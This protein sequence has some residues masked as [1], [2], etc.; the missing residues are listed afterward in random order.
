VKKPE[1]K[2]TPVYAAAERGH[3]EAVRVLVQ[4]GAELDQTNGVGAYI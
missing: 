1:N 4:A 3:V 2:E